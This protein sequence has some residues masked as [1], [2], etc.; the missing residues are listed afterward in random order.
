MSK[1]CWFIDWSASASSPWHNGIVQDVISLEKAAKIKNGSF[2]PEIITYW[3]RLDGIFLFQINF[4][5][6]NDAQSN[7]KN[8]EYVALASYVSSQIKRK[9]GPHNEPLAAVKSETKTGDNLFPTIS[10]SPIKISSTADLNEGNVEKMLTSDETLLS[11][12]A[13]LMGSKLNSEVPALFLL[14]RQFAANFEKA[15]QIRD[16]LKT[17]RF[18]NPLHNRFFKVGP[19]KLFRKYTWHA[20]LLFYFVMIFAN[21]A[22]TY[23]QYDFKNSNGNTTTDFK[24]ALGLTF[25]D[26]ILLVGVPVLV[27]IYILVV[28]IRRR[29]TLKA[30]SKAIHILN[31]G[32]I[33]CDVLSRITNDTKIKNNSG[34]FD[35]SIEVLSNLKQVEQDKRRDNLIMLYTSAAICAVPFYKFVGEKS[36]FIKGVIDIVKEAF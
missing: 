1:S 7:L 31:L 27:A 12:N 13:T 9:I 20:S 21:A 15:Y 22:Y 24:L 3:R 34:N 2:L 33:Y 10:T 6:S 14:R 19:E 28:Q 36:T 8:K 29:K 16:A 17:L 5:D 23:G 18:S 30:I 35:H 11:M 26:S 4:T 32:N 25:V